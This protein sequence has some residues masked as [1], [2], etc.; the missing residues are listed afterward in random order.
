MHASRGELVSYLD[1]EVPADERRALSAHLDDCERCAEVLEELGR[2]SRRLSAALEALDRPAPGIEAASIR[3]RAAAARPDHGSRTAGRRRRSLLAAAV[4]LIAFTGAAA[5]IPGSP[6]R[7]WLS[8]SVRTI[9]DFFDAGGEVPSTP[10]APEPE[11]TSRPPS[12]VAV[13]PHGGGVTIS[14]RSP[15]P[16][17]LVRV[18]L[19]EGPRASVLATGARYRTGAGSVEVLDAAA[20]EVTIEIP[21]AARWAVVEV[22]GRRIV[23]KRGDD[24]RLLAPADTSNSEIFFRPAG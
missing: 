5:A 19:V 24:L 9:A 11:A 12:G 7:A 22:D 15:S 18:R 23:E 13:A 1:G 20:G 17:A 2:L 8:D 16:D 10:A 14:L 6:L 21:R 4:L 3:R